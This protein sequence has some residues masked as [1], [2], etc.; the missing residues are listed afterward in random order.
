MADIL[1]ICYLRAARRKA[2]TV[3]TTEALSLLR[4]LD[5][6]APAGG[7]LSEQGGLFWVTLPAEVLEMAIARL[8]RLGYT[9]AVDM[10]EPLQEQQSSFDRPQEALAHL[11]RWHRKLYRL[12][13]IYE[14][15]AEALRESAPDRRVF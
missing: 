2:R 5:A 4:D 11:V 10:L 9:Y 3:A 15:D 12:V 6:A 8:P 14:E 7:P 13:R 1:L